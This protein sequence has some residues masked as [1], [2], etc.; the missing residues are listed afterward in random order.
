MVCAPQYPAVEIALPSGGEAPLLIPRI[1]GHQR[2]FDGL[3]SHAAIFTTD[4]AD[5]QCLAM[6]EWTPP[7]QTVGRDFPGHSANVTLHM[8]VELELNRSRAGFPS[9]LI[10]RVGDT[11]GTVDGKPIIAATKLA[12]SGAIVPATSLKERINA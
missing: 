1:R 3:L 10:I 7:H 9:S 11:F 5:G 8:P 6:W 12:I 2:N 4:G